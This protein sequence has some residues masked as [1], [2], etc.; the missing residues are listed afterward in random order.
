MGVWHFQHMNNICIGVL[1]EKK[2][3]KKRFALKSSPGNAALPLANISDCVRLFF[4]AVKQF[5]KTTN[6]QVIPSART[7]YCK[8]FWAF[9]SRVRCAGIGSRIADISLQDIHEFVRV[10]RKLPVKNPL[11]SV[12]HVN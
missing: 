3:G 6:A 10:V 4:N 8:S 12:F 5:E 7:A 2:G 9:G 1:P 11:K